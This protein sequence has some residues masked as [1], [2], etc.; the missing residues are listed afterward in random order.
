MDVNAF[1]DKEI[2]SSDVVIFSKSYCPY[3]KQTKEL[4]ASTLQQPA[5]I[6][7]LDQMADGAAIQNALQA[8]TGQRTVPNVFIKGNHLGGNDDTQQA[9]RDGRLAQMLA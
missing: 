6:H 2:T 3:C 7:E 4:F 5:A 1:I 9:H 8:K